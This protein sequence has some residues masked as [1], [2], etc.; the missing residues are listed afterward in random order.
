[1]AGHKKGVTV[2]HTFFVFYKSTLPH[3]F[4]AWIPILIVYVI[5]PFIHFG[6]YF[7]EDV[8]THDRKFWTMCLYEKL[9][10]SCEASGLVYAALHHYDLLEYLA[11]GVFAFCIVIC[12]AALFLWPLTIVIG[13]AYGVMIITRAIRRL[14]KMVSEIGRKGIS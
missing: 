1:M 13:V 11:L 12:G 3:M 6:Y 7:I 4:Y 10:L 9:P 14:Q 8:P 2:V 5:V